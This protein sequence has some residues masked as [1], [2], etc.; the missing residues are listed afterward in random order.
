M[1]NDPIVAETR[2]NRD[3]IARKFGYDMKKYCEY[4]NSAEFRKKI[5]ALQKRKK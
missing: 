4:L 5:A 1:F 3:K 2:R